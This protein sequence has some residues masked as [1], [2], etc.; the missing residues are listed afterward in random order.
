M[1]ISNLL[2]VTSPGQYWS[3]ISRYLSI[4]LAPWSRVILATSVTSLVALGAYRWSQTNQNVHPVVP[5]PAFDK[6]QSRIKSTYAYVFGG[7]A[8]TAAAAAISHISGLSRKILT[9]NSY[10]LP[11]GFAVLTCGSL[12]ATLTIPKENSKAQHVAWGIFNA[13][14]GLMLS[15]LGFINKAILAQAAFISLGVGGLLT[16]TAFLAP[17]KRF[18][19]WEGPLMAALTT[20]SIASAVAI[21]FPSSSFAYGVDRV[22]LYGGLALYS[23]L[24]M[25]STQRLIQEAETQSNQTFDPISSSM[26]IY[27]DS[28]NVFIRIL[29]ILAENDKKEEQLI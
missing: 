3:N 21:F 22:S 15:P 7:F 2:N 5:D 12:I 25:S 17:D 1:N 20:L 28:M 16:L 14:M 19:Q 9:N 6:V 13:S 27:L 18:L 23:G 8:L 29:R 4:S 10:I 24:L 11:I 26:S